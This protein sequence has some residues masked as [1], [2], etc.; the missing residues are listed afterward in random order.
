[1]DRDDLKTLSMMFGALLFG[2][3]LFLYL[4]SEIGFINI[5]FSI[6]FLPFLLGGIFIFYIPVAISYLFFKSRTP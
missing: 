2:I 5:K 4:F 6:N 3:P 1:M